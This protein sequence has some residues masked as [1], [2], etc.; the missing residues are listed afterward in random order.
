MTGFIPVKSPEY[1]KILKEIAAVSELLFGR[2]WAEKNAGNLSVD[3]TDFFS[4]EILKKGSGYFSLDKRF[5]NLGNRVFLVTPSGSRFR[6]IAQD[7]A[8][9]MMLVRIN[10]SGTGYYI[11]GKNSGRRPTSELRTHLKIHNYLRESRSDMRVVLHTHPTELIAL[12]HIKK[13]QSS[14]KLSDILVSA[15]PEVFINLPD[16]IGFVKYLLTGSERLA[17]ATLNALESGKTLIVW[18]RHGALSVERDVMTA[19]EHLDIANKAADITLRL[20]M[21]G[22]RPEMLTQRE[23]RELKGLF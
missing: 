16:R 22:V 9:Q 19:F 6:E 5:G 13:F 23:F 18:E 17:E 10:E 21:A 3:I 4:P 7:V 8:S 12:S 2:G 1:I 14:K 11:H 15:H 20:L